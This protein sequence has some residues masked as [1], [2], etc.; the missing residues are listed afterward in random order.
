MESVFFFSPRGGWGNGDMAGASVV[1]VV[2]AGPAPVDAPGDAGDESPAERRRLLNSG[3]VRRLPSA[4]L[5]H[6]HRGAALVPGRLP[7]HIDLQGARGLQVPGDTGRADPGAPPAPALVHGQQRDTLAV[8]SQPV[9]V[10]NTGPHQEEPR[11]RAPC[12]GAPVCVEDAG[13]RT[14]GLQGRRGLDHAE[15]LRC[16]NREVPVPGGF[17]LPRTCPRRPPRHCRSTGWTSSRPVPTIGTA[18]TLRPT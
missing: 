5:P 3:V 9:A 14:P 15:R 8:C 1:P 17:P 18:T 11:R 2:V 10:G 12:P 7:Q 16:G 6:S 4:G 13:G